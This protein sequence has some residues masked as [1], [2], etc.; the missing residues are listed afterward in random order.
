MGLILTPELIATS[1]KEHFAKLGEEVQ[2]TL[3]ACKLLVFDFDGVFTDNK[4]WLDAQGNELARCDRSDGFGIKQLQDAGLKIHILTTEKVTIANARAAKL[5]IPC[6][7]DLADKGLAL[8]ELMDSL[9]INPDQIVYVGNDLN[10][11][12]CFKIA[13]TTIA[14]A[15]AYEPIREMATFVT[16]ASGGN[17]AVREILAY[18]VLAR[19]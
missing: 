5:K 8:Q 16:L 7:N 1:T 9:G 4:V 12:P 14:V 6:K 10:D 13:G 17:G 18:F 2:A 19:S 3:R 11:L 15:D